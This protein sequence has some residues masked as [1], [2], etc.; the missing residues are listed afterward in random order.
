MKIQSVTIEVTPVGHLGPYD[1][2]ALTARING[3]LVGYQK[4]VDVDDMQSRFDVVMGVAV[5][6]LK[7]AILDKG[8][9]A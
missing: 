6:C 8:G 2:L 5:D 1:K 4:V 9:A 7:R 3:R